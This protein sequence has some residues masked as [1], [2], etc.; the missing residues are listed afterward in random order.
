MLAELTNV[1][2]YSRRREGKDVG[3]ALGLKASKV[4]YEGLGWKQDVDQRSRSVVLSDL[5][6]PRHLTTGGPEIANISQQRQ[7]GM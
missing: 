1:G 4:L 7:E 6:S 5:T 3:S 2:G